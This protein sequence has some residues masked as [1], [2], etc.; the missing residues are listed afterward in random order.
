MSTMLDNG[1]AN[2]LTPLQL[3][4]ELTI[5][6]YVASGNTTPWGRLDEDTKDN[7]RRATLKTMEFMSLIKRYTFKHDLGIVGMDENDQKRLIKAWKDWR[8]VR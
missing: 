2:R 4:E 7:W 6:E 3:L 5:I 8:G 1:T